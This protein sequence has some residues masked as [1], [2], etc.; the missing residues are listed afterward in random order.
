MRFIRL[1]DRKFSILVN[2]SSQ[3]RL[4]QDRRQI[5]HHLVSV[6]SKNR[7][8]AE[9]PGYSHESTLLLDYSSWV[10]Y[11]IAVKDF[12]VD[13][14]LIRPKSCS[15]VRLTGFGTTSEAVLAFVGL[16]GSG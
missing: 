4:P 13:R 8:L 15:P 5:E 7:T 12:D 1:T 6:T 3:L 2:C 14:L 11:R 16:T 10:F 9:R